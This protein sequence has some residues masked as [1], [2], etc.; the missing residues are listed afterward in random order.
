MAPVQQIHEL[1]TAGGDI[2]TMM[3]G[4]FDHDHW[5]IKISRTELVAIGAGAACPAIVKGPWAS[6]VCPP[7]VAALNWAI[8]RFPI[9]NGFWAEV[10]TNGR[11]NL[12]TR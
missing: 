12:S 3:H 2:T 6:V 4:G 8:G 1:G 11:V 5:W 7:L 10:Y 9:A